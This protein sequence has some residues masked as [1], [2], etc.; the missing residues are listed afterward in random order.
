MAGSSYMYT[1]KRERQ[2][3]F[4]F[5]YGILLV[6]SLSFV[7]CR[8]Q[9]EQSKPNND[10]ITHASGFSSDQQDDYVL[11]TVHNP[12]EKGKILQKYVLVSKDRELPEELPEGILVRTPL[13]N[14]VCFS[15]VICGFLEELGVSQTITGVAESQYIKIPSV[16][17]G[18]KQGEIIDVGQAANP[19]VEKLFILNPEVILA[20]MLQDVGI[21]QVNKTNISIIECLEYMETLP[22]GQTEWI[23]FLAFFFD[24]KEEAD[25]IFQETEYRYN[26]LKD[27]LNTITHRPTVFTE[28]MYSGVWYIPGGNS[29]IAHLLTDAGADYLW[30]ED[31]NSGAINCSFEQVLGKA[32]KADYWLIKDFSPQTIT[33]SNLLSKNVNY[34]IFDAYVNKNIFVCNTHQVMYYEDIPIHPDRVLENLIYI[35]HPE[36]RGEPKFSYYKPMEN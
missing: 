26:A 6:F 11:L 33:Y 24:K 2:K 16:Q 3:S 1:N 28:T 10:N 13:E 15:S 32:E 36:V 14:V 22:L 34:A 23:K 25:R 12:W 17:E 27:K 30:K 19:D 35:F 18:I 31:T 4:L 7:S 8:K 20:N 9:N 29:Y 5:I 21:G